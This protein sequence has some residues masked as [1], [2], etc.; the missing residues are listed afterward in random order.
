M[1]NKNP[2][3]ILVVDDDPGHRTTL[4]TLLKTWGY[5]ISEAGDGRA[6][7]DRVKQNPYEL[8]LMDVRMAEMGGIDALKE[9]KAY[10]PAIPIVIMT[11]YSSVQS[12]VEAMKAGAYDYLTKPLDFD[13][14]QL[15]IQ[16]ALEHTRL[17][18]ENQDLKARLN[19]LAESRRI[20]SAST[21]M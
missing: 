3:E 15:T 16:R 13:E 2:S 6:A 12:A 17:K 19:N 7:V 5:N 9:I 21:E 14:L 18:H 8:I 1:E 10:N 11:A 20:V 4:K